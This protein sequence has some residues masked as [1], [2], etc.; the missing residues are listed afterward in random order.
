LE[1][2]AIIFPP[3]IDLINRFV[4][5]STVRFLISFLFCAILG[6]GLNW[7]ETGFVFP[8]RLMA[9]Q[10]LSGSILAVFGA[11]QLSYQAVYKESKL[12]KA[13][14]TRVGVNER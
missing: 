14:D 13:I 5:D 10:S 9:F 1:L 7:I 8:D 6:I 4:K 2:I 3:I 11:T 12:Q